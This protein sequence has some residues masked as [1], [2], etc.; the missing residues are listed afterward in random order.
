ME[1]DGTEEAD[2]HHHR[3]DS[4]RR[5]AR[6]RKIIEFLWKVLIVFGAGVLPL[7]AVKACEWVTYVRPDR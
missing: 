3:E 5:R 7:L 1:I 6:R 4:H 2:S